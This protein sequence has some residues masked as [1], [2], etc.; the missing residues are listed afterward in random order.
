MRFTGGRSFFDTNVLVYT[1][2]GD[3]PDKQATALDLMAAARRASKGVVSTQVLQEYFV[4]ATSKLGVEAGLARR[5][6]ELFGRLH[7]QIVDLEDV[8][9]ATDLRIVHRISFWD[10]LIIAAAKR[11]GCRRL[12]TEDLGT[13]STLAGVEIV[14]PFA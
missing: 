3:A 1:D 4:A 13:G 14:N 5:K 10:A 8:L 6:V 11:A 9:A 7:L 12:Y 2:D